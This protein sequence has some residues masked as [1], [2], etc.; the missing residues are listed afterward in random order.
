MQNAGQARAASYRYR[1]FISADGVLDPAADEPI[2][3][4]GQ[5]D[6]SAPGASA[7]AWSCLLATIYAGNWR[8]AVQIDPGAQLQE[9]VPGVANNLLVGG[10]LTVGQ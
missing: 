10:A 9:S 3:T 8:L 7:T 6:G 1:F 4:C 5:V 2:G